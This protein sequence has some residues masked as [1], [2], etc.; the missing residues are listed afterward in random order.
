MQNTKDETEPAWRITSGIDGAVIAGRRHRA[1][2][3]ADADVRVQS[4]RPPGPAA[5]G[6]VPADSRPARSTSSPRA[7]SRRSPSTSRAARRRRQRRVAPG[8]AVRLRRRRA[9]AAAAPKPRGQARHAPAATKVSKSGL[10]SFTREMAN[11]LAAGLPLSRALACSSARRRSRGEARLGRGPRRRRRRHAAGRRA[12]EVAADLLQR[13]RRDGPRGRGGRVP[14]VV[15]QQIADFR[16]REQDLKGKVKAAM[17]YPIVLACMATAVLV[18]P[19]DVL[20]PAVQH[21]LRRVRRRPAVPHAD[22]RR[23]QH[24]GDEV[25]PVRR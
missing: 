8:P 22:H 18:V 6:T 24:A 25:R 23:R 11:L 17:V 10:E 1:G 2:V 12:G 15:L 13:L 7:G 3:S 19:A 9:E 20:H 4:A 16:T 21:D 14:P 5:A